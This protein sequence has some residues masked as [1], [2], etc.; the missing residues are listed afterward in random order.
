MNVTNA[1]SL[2][3]TERKMSVWFY[4]KLGE[5]LVLFDGEATYWTDDMIPSRGYFRKGKKLYLY[6]CH[7][8]DL[9]YIGEL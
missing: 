8:T 6:K 3:R 5:G 4:P 2:R 1:L 7:L 9:I